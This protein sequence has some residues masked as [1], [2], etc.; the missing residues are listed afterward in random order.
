MTA[1]DT[2]A[3]GRDVTAAVRVRTEGDVAEEDL[4]YVRE[5]VGAALDRSGLPPVSGE[6][7]ITRAAA[8]HVEQ[9]WSAAAEIRVGGDLVVVHAQEAS[10]REL[11]DRLQNRLR[12]RTERTAHRAD[13]ARRT[14]TP[15]PW[16]GG[17]ER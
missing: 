3:H 4:A 12:S 5:K 14:A 10:A 9:P 16:R 1:S 11:A 15:P 2:G 7:R 13:T 6:V 17:P 8:P